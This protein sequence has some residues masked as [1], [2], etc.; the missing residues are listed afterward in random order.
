MRF[1]S[2]KNYV[3]FITVDTKSITEVRRLYRRYSYSMKIEQRFIKIKILSFWVLFA[4]NSSFLSQWAGKYHIFQS[5]WLLYPKNFMQHCKCYPICY[6]YNINW[7]CSY[8]F[9]VQ[10]NHVDHTEMIL[11]ILSLGIAFPVWKFIMAIL[12]AI[13]K[14]KLQQRKVNK[15]NQSVEITNRCL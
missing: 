2:Q 5:P 6:I 12:L 10:F 9:I 15:I 1:S 8:L 7:H 13:K 14:Y 4:V 11:I 3:I